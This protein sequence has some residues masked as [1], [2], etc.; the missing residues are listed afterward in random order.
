VSW[1]R[2]LGGHEAEELLLRA[3]VVPTA[4]RC[5]AVGG[6]DEPG[7]R[8]RAGGTLAG[9]SNLRP[10]DVQEQLVVVAAAV[11]SGLLQVGSFAV[12]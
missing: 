4:E 3:V 6:L 12:A 9:S 11:A 8:L 10:H 2:V 7:V 5:L 1:R